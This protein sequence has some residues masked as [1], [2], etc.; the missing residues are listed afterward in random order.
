MASARYRKV[1]TTDR[2][3]A[4][5]P[6]PA[7]VDVCRW[8]VNR[9]CSSGERKTSSS[10]ARMLWPVS[11]R[12]FSSSQAGFLVVMSSS[13]RGK[14]TPPLQKE[15][16]PKRGQGGLLRTA[17]RV[18]CNNIL[19][20]S[21][22][23]GKQIARQAARRSHLLASRPPGCK[24]DELRRL[25]LLSPV[26]GLPCKL[27]GV[28]PAATFMLWQPVTSYNSAEGAENSPPSVFG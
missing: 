5:Y 8:G 3:P 1:R 16:P 12:H 4:V 20:P 11:S 7:G 13:C 26:N 18:P 19:S 6:W 15:A 22:R 24:P 2:P 14:H 25:N 27:Q 10:D 28:S 9:R 23:R 21:M 17:R